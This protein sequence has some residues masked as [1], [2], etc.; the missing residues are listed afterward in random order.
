MIMLGFLDTL[1]GTNISHHWGKENHLQIVPFGGDML[2]SWRVLVMG[3]CRLI[4]IKNRLD[5]CI[6][7]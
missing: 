5:T 4:G 6:P 7:S 1:Q 3:Q 2:V